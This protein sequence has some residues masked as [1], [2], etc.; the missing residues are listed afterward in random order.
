MTAIQALLA[1]TGWTLALVMGI[2]L[3]RG[4]RILQ[5]TPI[6]HCRSRSGVCG[7]YLA[8]Y[9]LKEKRAASNLSGPRSPG[10]GGLPARRMV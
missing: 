3:Y 2:F 7:R 9:F 10:P 4:L 8:P 6:T 5:G 1:F